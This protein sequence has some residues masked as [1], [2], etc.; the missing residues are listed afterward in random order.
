M[1]S[2]DINNDGK[3]DLVIGSPFASVKNLTQNGMVTAL[4]SSKSLGKTESLI[5]YE[6]FTL[7]SFKCIAFRNESLIS[8]TCL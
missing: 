6:E 1:T 3:D 5:Q 8:K 4:L 2:L 7:N